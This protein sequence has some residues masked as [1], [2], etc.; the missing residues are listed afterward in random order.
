VAATL[1]V[2]VDGSELAALSKIA[3][4]YGRDGANFD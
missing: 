4:E 1:A 2:I 3:S